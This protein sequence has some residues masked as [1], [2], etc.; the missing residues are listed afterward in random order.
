[1]T[2]TPE[3]PAYDAAATIAATLAFQIRRD[4]PPH[5][6]PARRDAHPKHHGTVQAEFRVRNDVPESLRHGVLATPGASYPAWIR[7][8]NA[9]RVRHDL[10]AD[11]RGMAV[12]LMGVDP[13]RGD[14]TQDFLMV[15]FPAFFAATATDFI[16]F[17]SA[18]L[19]ASASDGR[20]RAFGVAATFVRILRLFF[21][22]RPFRF[23]WRAFRAFRG[24]ATRT[25]SP[26]TLRYFS[27]TPYR[28]GPHVVKF[29]V[30]P[31]QQPSF[32]DRVRL[33]W[34]SFALGLNM[35]PFVKL[36]LPRWEHTLRDTLFRTLA[37]RGADFDF[38]V[39]RQTDPE[40]MPI[41]NATV[42]WSE[43]RSP[44]IPVAT[45]HIPAQPL[46]AAAIDE[47]LAF[48]E[49]L[50]FTPWH[51]LPAHQ[52][53]GSINEARRVVYE[54]IS[55]LR[56]ELNHHSRREPRAGESPADYLRSLQSR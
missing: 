8:S 10:V 52:P 55:S 41:D 29:G 36:T 20:T 38:V 45:I 34:L 37:S 21:R 17:P 7:F 18:L 25:L 22:L 1:M 4:Y 49:Q 51:M 35:L 46:D 12:K 15:T 48:S 50:S 3:G 53:L 5:R 56:H 30:R 40:R 44:F 31:H 13:A 27:Q 9:F 23:R 16:E 28:L 39:Q 14:A 24:S 47:R 19:P 26:L 32:A 42:I 11:A 6:L 33:R 2:D 54:T 43:A